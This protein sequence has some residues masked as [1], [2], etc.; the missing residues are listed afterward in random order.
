MSYPDPPADG[1]MPRQYLN[2]Q[3]VLSAAERARHPSGQRLVRGK[4]A[5]GNRIMVRDLVR[6]DGAR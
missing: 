1:T 2:S 4:P 3:I 6:R 5:C